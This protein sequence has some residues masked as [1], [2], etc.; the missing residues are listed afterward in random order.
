MRTV[1]TAASV[2]GWLA[3]VSLALSAPVSTALGDG[4]V[5]RG[6]Y[7]ASI[8]DCTG[9][10]TGGA[11]VGA[12][13]PARHLAGSDIGFQ[14]PGLGVFYPPN[15]TSDKET[16]LG[17]WSEDEIIA[18]VRTGARPDGRMLAPVMPWL[19]YAALT[20]EDARALAAYIKSLPPVAFKAPGPFGESEAPTAPYL[21]VVM[22]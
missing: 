5:E 15:L 12:P 22:P 2:A 9:C 11:L 19:S 20:D 3:A 6:A 13:D 17:N 18:A 14:V 7:L 16:G 10:H 21:T 1:R 4:A 8:M